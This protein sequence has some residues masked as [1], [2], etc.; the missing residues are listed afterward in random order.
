MPIPKRCIFFIKDAYCSARK[1]SCK[2]WPCEEVGHYANECQYMNNQNLNEALGTLH[3][4]ELSEQ[5]VAD[6]L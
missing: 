3:Y 1:N 4:S 6:K 2:C 5:E